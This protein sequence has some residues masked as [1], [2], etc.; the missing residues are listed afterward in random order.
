MSYRL[1]CGEQGDRI[2]AIAPVAGSIL[3]V[4]S[5]FTQH[6]GVFANPQNCSSGRPVPILH[7]HGTADQIVGYNGTYA[8]NVKLYPGARESL[9]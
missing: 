7:F 6:T 1:A 2:K 8:L 9:Q 5:L 3:F 4:A